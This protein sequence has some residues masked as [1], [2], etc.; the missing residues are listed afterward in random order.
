MLKEEQV[1]DEKWNIPLRNPRGSNNSHRLMS[2]IQ[3]DQGLELMQMIEFH[4]MT[5][6]KQPSS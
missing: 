1:E 2:D 4:I 6:G 5:N 3:P